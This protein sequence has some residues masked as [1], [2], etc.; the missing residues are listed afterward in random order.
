MLTR[1]LHRLRRRLRAQRGFTLV[2]LCVAMA[3]GL[4]VLFGLASIMVVAMHQTQ[5]TFTTIDATRQARTAL[6]NIENELHSACVD[7]SP[8]IQGVTNGVTESDANNLDFIS[9][10][11]TS[12]SPVPVWHD[13]TFTA[14]T[15]TLID[16]TYN[17][18]GTSPDW[19][20]GT[21]LLSKNTLLTNAAPV[22][23]T[24][25]VFQYFAYQLE[26]ADAGGNNYW[27]VP[28]GTGSVPV[29]GVTPA[30]A[31]LSTAGGLAGDDADNTVEVIINLLVGPSSS[32]LNNRSL[33]GASAPVT[34]AI[35]L[36]LTTPPDYVPATVTVAAGDTPTGY[37]PC[38]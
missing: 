13:L 16:Y 31:P 25:P 9:F 32:R 28:D 26:Y 34:D 5:R 2:E 8:P 27:I 24:T 20:E 17:V 33:S 3:A 6:A 29:T 38:E 21:T 30:A 37:G 23:S 10:T 36:R 12:A 11:G 1:A 19:A 7:G 22:T 18:A 14:G 15:G 35:S 4:V